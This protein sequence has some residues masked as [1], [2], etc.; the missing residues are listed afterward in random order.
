M[1][2]DLTPLFQVFAS[3]LP[4]GWGLESHSDIVLEVRN[5]GSRCVRLFTLKPLLWRGGDYTTLPFIVSFAISLR[6]SGTHAVA[7]LLHSVP[8]NGFYN[9]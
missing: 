7:D 3:C 2:K 5:L 6:Y 9:R 1:G 8:R 4:L